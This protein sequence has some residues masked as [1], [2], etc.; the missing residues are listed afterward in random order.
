MR[1]SLDQI[2]T[3]NFVD[4]PYFN[5]NYTNDYKLLDNVFGKHSLSKY[6]EQIPMKD[7]LLFSKNLKAISKLE[8]GNA[9][10][11]LLEDFSQFIPNDILLNYDKL[12]NLLDTLIIQNNAIL[13]ENYLDIK[14]NNWHVETL[15]TTNKLLCEGEFMS[16]CVGGY[17]NS[18]KS[19]RSVI[20]KVSGNDRFTIELSIDKNNN[21]ELAQI[22]GKRNE[23]I[24]WDRASLVLFEIDKH[25]K[26]FPM[27]QRTFQY[28]LL[29]AS[30][31]E[32]INETS[33]LLSDGI[34]FIPEDFDSKKENSLEPLSE[35][36]FNED[37]PE[38][39]I[40]DDDI[41]F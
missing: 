41:P 32:H 35:Y 16:H 23:F 1:S 10:F 5:E 22:K 36:S 31:L 39:D 28:N 38:I 30:S 17:S 9:I 15:R 24:T 20:L 29:P 25:F 11:G 40:G 26:I 33:R 7:W 13:S 14:F 27:S 8:F 6:L 34:L 21:F 4:L 18:V 19:N 12:R 2:E 3:L 37:I